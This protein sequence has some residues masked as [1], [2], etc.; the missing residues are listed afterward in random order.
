MYT[1]VR[2]TKASSVI[3][4]WLPT[5]SMERL[6]TSVRC[7]VLKKWHLKIVIQV[8]ARQMRWLV[9]WRAH[10]ISSHP[11]WSLS[12]SFSYLSAPESFTVV[13]F[14]THGQQGRQGW[15]H[16][17]VPSVAFSLNPVFYHYYF[18]LW[19]LREWSEQ[20]KQTRRKKHGC[21]FQMRDR[22]EI[23][24]HVQGEGEESSFPK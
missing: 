12:L 2:I 9:D 15:W 19:T 24:R 6:K 14:S 20:E 13:A 8:L 18:F 7:A 23:Q 3:S 1:Y 4:I 16:P 22:R 11:R 21:V 17:L 5:L 10:H